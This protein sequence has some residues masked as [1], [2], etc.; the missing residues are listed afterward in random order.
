MSFR[1]QLSLTISLLCALIIVVLSGYFLVIQNQ[2]S[3][4]QFSQTIQSELKTLDFLSSRAILD[5]DDFALNDSLNNLKSIKG[6]MG[7]EF[8]DRNGNRLLA[9]IYAKDKSESKFPP[10]FKLESSDQVV[11]GESYD[12]YIHNLII[13]HPF[14]KDSPPT[15]GFARVSFSDKHIRDQIFNSFFTNNLGY[16]N[17]SAH[18]I[19]GCNPNCQ[20]NV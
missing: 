10:S 20:A 1:G 12:I 15:L 2:Q 16:S 7:S 8:Y 18:C 4:E 13:L 6:F 3:R 5:Q 17:Y 14:I 19:F 9:S 11:P